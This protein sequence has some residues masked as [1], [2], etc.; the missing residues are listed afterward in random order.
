MQTAQNTQDED[1]AK[2]FFASLATATALTKDRQ[3]VLF[4]QRPLLPLDGREFSLK[5]SRDSSLSSIKGREKL[6]AGSWYNPEKFCLVPSQETF[7]LV[8]FGE[9]FN[10]DVTRDEAR[11]EGLELVSGIWAVP[12]MATFPQPDRRCSIIFGG[13]SPFWKNPDGTRCVVR[14]VGTN[15]GWS[16]SMPWASGLTDCRKSMWAVK[17][18]SD[19]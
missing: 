4:E 11:K 14:I 19:G 5:L 6:D 17:K 8:S 15:S 13:M 9:I 16:V 3:I 10:L 1:K 2:E 18:I 7:H 12:F